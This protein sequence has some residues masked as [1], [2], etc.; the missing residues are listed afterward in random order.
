MN[1]VKKWKKKLNTYYS[2]LHSQKLLSDLETS[3]FTVSL[4]NEN[5]T[6]L[7]AQVMANREIAGSSALKTTIVSGDGSLAVVLK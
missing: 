4:T 6:K 1:K 3:G 5:H 7:Y 2:D